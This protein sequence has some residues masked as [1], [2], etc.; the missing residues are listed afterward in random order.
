MWYLWN[1][2]GFLARTCD[3]CFFALGVKP[4]TVHVIRVCRLTIPVSSFMVTIHTLS[5]L[6]SFSIYH[7]GLYCF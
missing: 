1:V 6:H 2:S 5:P 7:H 3:M 4:D